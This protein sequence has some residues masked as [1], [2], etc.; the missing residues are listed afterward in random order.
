MPRT[1]T[2]LR[3]LHPCLVRPAC[4]CFA[5]RG[6][7]RGI[8]RAVR[9]GGAPRREGALRKRAQVPLRSLGG[10][11]R[12]WLAVRSTCTA[13]LYLTAPPSCGCYA[14]NQ[15]TEAMRGE[16]TRRP[17]ERGTGI[18]AKRRPVCERNRQRAGEG[19]ERSLGDRPPRARVPPL[20]A[21]SPGGV[22]VGERLFHFALPVP[23]ALPH[24]RSV[25]GTGQP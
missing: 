16:S 9:N 22:P 3:T 14:G 12:S 19:R 1:G 10:G 13:A 5:H 24:G 20:K 4:V 21:A 6:F 23:A 11:L 25:R 15:G 17:V 8:P 18:A 7:A 2:F